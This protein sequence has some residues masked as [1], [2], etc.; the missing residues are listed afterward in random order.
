M[1]PTHAIRKAAPSSLPAPWAIGLF[2]A[3]STF[4]ALAL[5]LVS[6]GY[7]PS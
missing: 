5:F 2:L 1:I 4:A 3:S 7:I 6:T